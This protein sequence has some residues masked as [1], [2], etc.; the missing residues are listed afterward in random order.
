MWACPV[1]VYGRASVAA[2]DPTLDAGPGTSEMGGFRL[3]GDGCA[4]ARMRSI[5]A[6]IL[7]RHRPTSLDGVHLHSHLKCVRWIRYSDNPLEKIATIAYGAVC[8]ERIGRPSASFDS[9]LL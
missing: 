1:G 8:P 7:L 9:F 3:F 4:T 2:G 6:V 5:A